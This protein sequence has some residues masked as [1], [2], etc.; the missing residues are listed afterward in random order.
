MGTFSDALI[1]GTLA[2]IASA[3]TATAAGRATGAAPAA[4]LNAVSH[5]LWGDRAAQQ[6]AASGR[7]TVTGFVI[8]H[9]ASIFWA[10]CYSALR[11]R[12]G[13]GPAGAL[14]SAAATAGLAYFVDYHL[15]PRRL[16]PGYELRLSGKQIALIYAAIALSLPLGDLLRAQAAANL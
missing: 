8:N 5:V 3:A 2:G 16:T 9:A 12:V 13:R 10:T 4:A 6:N 7:Y 15:V 11:R 14:A 1:S